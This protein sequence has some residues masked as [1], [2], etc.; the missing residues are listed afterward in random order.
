M[1]SLESNPFSE[2]AEIYDQ[3]YSLETNSEWLKNLHKTVTKLGIC[4]GT[5]LDVGSGTGWSTTFWLNRGFNVYCLDNAFQMIS[6]CSNKYPEL[7]LKCVCGTYNCIKEKPTFELITAVNDVTN[8]ILYQD[9]TISSFFKLVYSAL[10]QNGI[11]AF[12]LMTTQAC[13]LFPKKRTYNLGQ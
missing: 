9:D 10:K 8:Y 2:L 5:V 3:I 13:K 12:D 11:F 6:H 7:K 1:D 4:N